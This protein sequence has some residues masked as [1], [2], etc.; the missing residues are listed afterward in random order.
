MRTGTADE[1]IEGGIDS[2]AIGGI[3]L[4]SLQSRPPI[5]SFE[6]RALDV[7]TANDADTNDEGPRDAPDGRFVQHPR[8]TSSR[9]IAA[10]SLFPSYLE[11]PRP[12][13]RSMPRIDD[14]PAHCNHMSGLSFVFL[15]NVG[16]R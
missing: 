5:R 8:S 7:M 3:R 9:V 12:T 11:A 15:R 13:M 6:R 10:S 16:L 4:K 1:A 2:F 14:I